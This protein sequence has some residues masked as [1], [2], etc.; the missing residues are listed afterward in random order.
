MSEGQ[1]VRELS[2]AADGSMPA[3]RSYGADVS[4]S[5]SFSE[6][7]SVHVRSPLDGLV[8]PFGAAR[9]ADQPRRAA[10]RAV[11]RA[12]RPPRAGAGALAASLLASAAVI[13]GASTAEAAPNPSAGVAGTQ[14]RISPTE[15]PGFAQIVTRGDFA[16]G[17]SSHGDIFTWGDNREGQLPGQGAGSDRLVPEQALV[18]PDGR[19]K[20]LAAY[21]TGGYAL[22]HDGEVWAWGG[23]DRGQLGAGGAPVNAQG[24][25]R[26]DGLESVV[27]VVGGG[28]SGYALTAQGEVWAWGANDEGQ[29]GDGT[30]VDRSTPVKVQGLQGVTQIA[31]AEATAYALSG[32]DQVWAWGRNAHGELGVGR[33]AAQLP[34]SLEP[35]R[36]QGLNNI[37]QI[38]G[39][40]DGGYAL[41]YGGH[42]R[43][44]G[45][46]DL[47]QVGD[48]TREDRLVPALLWFG[49]VAMAQIAGGAGGGYALGQ[50]SYVYSWGSNERGRL[51]IGEN[52]HTYIAAVPQRAGDIAGIVRLANVT[53][54]GRSSGYADLHMQALDKSRD[55]A[56]FWGPDDH[57]AG[58]RGDASPWHTGFS[59][60]MLGI[61]FQTDAVFFGALPGLN[62]GQN[63]RTEE[64]FATAPQAAAP[65]PVAVYAESMLRTYLTEVERFRFELGTFT[66]L[67]EFTEVTAPTVPSRAAVETPLTATGTV[68]S[69]LN[70][71]VDDATIVY[72][73]YRADNQYDPGSYLQT[74]TEYVPSSEDL[75]TYIYAVAAASKQYYLGG[76]SAESAR[77][78]VEEGDFDSFERPIIA[79]AGTSVFRTELRVENAPLAY[80]PDAYDARLSYQWFRDGQAIDGATG[81]RY[82]TTEADA[83]HEIT[84]WGTVSAPGMQRRH[85]APSEPVSIDFADFVRV[86]PPELSNARLKTGTEIT[87]S[88]SQAFDITGLVGDAELSYRWYVSENEH[89][90]GILAQTGAS[91]TP[92]EAHEGRWVSVT[93]TATRA[94][95]R[96]MTSDPTRPGRTAPI[97]DPLLTVSAPE[98]EGTL[99][100]GTPVTASGSVASGERGAIDDATIAYRWYLADDPRAKGKPI[101]EGASVTPA[102]EHTGK[103]L[104]VIASAS[105]TGYRDGRSAETRTAKVWNQ[106]TVSL[107]KP[108]IHQGER[109]AVTVSGLVPGETVH[110]EVRSEPVRLGMQTADASGEARFEF[111]APRDFETGA[112]TVLANGSLS[113]TANAPLRVEPA[114]IDPDG[115]AD[116]GEGDPS[117]DPSD[118]PS[119]DPSGD[120]SAEPERGDAP[121]LSATGS[122]N[123]LA[124]AAAGLLILVAGVPLLFTRRTKA[125]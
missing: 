26:V 110:A 105:K 66:N 34:R 125:R 31:A 114:G 112:H 10:R 91:F 29:L 92:A 13:A 42:V 86:T 22:T 118:E 74:D 119:G 120:P 21:S 87:A 76:T 38:A 107:S 44:W 68:A 3:I 81:E 65:G 67:F 18:T 50:D 84:V 1:R 75:G 39:H 52:D 121:G 20:Q 23:N 59:G 94:G 17:L 80:A 43:A 109:V 14:I 106:P 2:N 88:G 103:Y 82:T 45:R 64:L 19:A 56:L 28:D 24:S 95:Y 101:G 117:D 15:A 124:L 77:V 40:R 111:A 116:P 57:G 49:G 58:G 51:G 53:P 89:G 27:Q 78:L 41:G 90:P 6:E 93:A 83:G 47:G 33:T 36:I 100:T 108:S 104:Y 62:V 8:P 35:M 12:R 37:K 71:T 97:A 48:N 73:W 46:G 4:H 96:P 99:Q 16:L 7:M 98:I 69:D 72:R 55:G 9:R 54:E 63:D 79:P 25:V 113:R 115:G 123:T 61:N 11:R 102:V 60:P 5:D 122:S 30:Q 85:S 32:A 70:G